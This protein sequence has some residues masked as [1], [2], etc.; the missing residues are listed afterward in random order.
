MLTIVGRLRSSQRRRVRDGDAKLTIVALDAMFRDNV[1]G[2][3]LGPD[4]AWT[5]AR[6]AR[7]EEPFRAQEVLYR[8]AV[9]DTR[10][11]HRAAGI[12]LEPR[13]RP[14]RPPA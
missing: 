12:V 10:R 9:E 2:R 11:V 13:L 1:K 7:G 14:E 4:G 8:E 5:R 3:A 6:R